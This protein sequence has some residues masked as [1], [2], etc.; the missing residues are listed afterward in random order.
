MKYDSRC[1]GIVDIGWPSD[2]CYTYD[3][4]GNL[5]TE[6]YGC[7]GKRTIATPMMPL[8]T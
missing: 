3:T 7:N 4:N 8:V 5:L 2:V 6:D 1:N